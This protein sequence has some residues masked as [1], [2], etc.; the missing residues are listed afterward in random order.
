MNLEYRVFF[1]VMGDERE[2]AAALKSASKM[3]RY[4]LAQTL[5]L[6]VT[7]ELTFIADS[8]IEHGAHIA[9]IL[10]DLNIKND[11]EDSE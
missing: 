5:N 7:P 10:H 11:S 1:S 3:L 2:A 4:H 8:S 6:R 9:K